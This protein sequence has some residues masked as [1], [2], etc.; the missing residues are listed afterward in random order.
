[1]TRVETPAAAAAFV[2]LDR[3]AGGVSGSKCWLK[4]RCGWVSPRE[5]PASRKALVRPVIQLFVRKTFRF[6]AALTDESDCPAGEVD[7]SAAEAD[8]LMDANV[9]RHHQSDG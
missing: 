6:A 4:R 9:C 3:M 7:V 8:H 5:L 2:S 1:M